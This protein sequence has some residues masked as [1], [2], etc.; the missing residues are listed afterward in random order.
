MT[1]LNTLSIRTSVWLFTA[2]AASGS[3]LG[4]GFAQWQ[5]Y[6]SEVVSA[7]LLASVQVARAAGQV[8][9]MHDGL[10]ATALSA[11]LAGPE[12]PAQEKQDILAELEEFRRDMR[13][14]LTRVGAV[15]ADESIRVAVREVEPV[16]TR[17]LTG[18]QS[19]IETAFKDGEAARHMR[20]ALEADFKSL[21]ES[22]GKLSA[23]V[24]AEAEAAFE[25]REEL[26]NR[27][28]WL[29]PLLFGLSVALV[30]GF[31][32]PFARRV[33]RAL[34]AEP[35]ELSSFAARIAEGQLHA[36]FR[37]ASQPSGSVAASMVSMRDRLRDAVMVIRQGAD[38]V[39]SG[40]QQIRSANQH[41]AERTEH[42][43][44]QLQQ[45]SSSME[46]ISGGVQHTAENAAAASRLADNVSEAAS[47]AGEAVNQV[48][49]TMEQ[50]QGSSQRIAEIIGVID[51]IA[52]QTNILAL[53]A[54]VEAA[55]AGDQGRG[56]AVVATEVRS[57]AQRSASAARE[58]KALIESSGKTVA[59]GS[60]IVLTAGNTMQDLQDRVH[61]VHA[62]IAKISDATTEQTHG[63]G[64]VNA[65][66]STLDAATQ[67]NAGMVEQSA[68]AAGQL[69]EQAQRLAQAV[70]IF[71]L[72]SSKA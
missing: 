13:E 67:S 37:S 42:Q 64:A 31:G 34:G 57:L 68:V 52:L 7:R 49:T 32:I 5:A 62:L 19:L 55:R 16:V 66:V 45:T 58:I 60:Q 38:F 48:V 70:S 6:Q 10:R 51:G 15:S 40:S 24:E 23:L 59:D 17:Y 72:E 47:R 21:E 46:E 33:M 11:L 41:L 1:W 18:A 4:G 9:M 43:A 29:T 36:A 65:A 69:E 28:R 63:I 3:L 22:L 27:S 61:E 44:Q 54:A 14:S 8:D 30:V 50:I 20:P 2:L 26:V 39:A 53:N 12:A 56:F 35:H 25:R 71:K